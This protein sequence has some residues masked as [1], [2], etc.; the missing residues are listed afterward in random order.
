MPYLPEFMGIS[1]L[2][3]LLVM[4]LEGSSVPFPGILV[5]IACGSSLNMTVPEMGAAALG[6]SAAYCTASL[7]PYWLGLKM[8]N[9]MKRRFEKKISSAQ[10]LFAKY[11]ELSI[12]LTRP[13]AIGNYISY[14]AGISRT[15][16]RKYAALT[17]VGIYPWSFGLLFLSGVYKHSTLSVLQLLEANIEYAYAGAAAII[18][19]YAVILLHRR[20]SLEKN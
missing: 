18:V 14:V 19:T 6:M 17:L 3:L 4:A 7:I 20:V 1:I 8:E 9:R 5:V 10:H 15:N 11:G 16:L 13:F 2:T 12:A